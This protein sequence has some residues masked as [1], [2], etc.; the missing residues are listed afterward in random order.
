MFTEKVVPVCKLLVGGVR[1]M[2][3]ADFLASLSNP[4]NQHFVRTT[5][6][7]LD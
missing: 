7:Y 1:L 4:K 5:L 3:I 2:Q 6:G